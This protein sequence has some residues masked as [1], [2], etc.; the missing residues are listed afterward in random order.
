METFIIQK[1]LSSL[2]L[3]LILLTVKQHQLQTYMTR[4]P[5]PF[6]FTHFLFWIDIH[7]LIFMKSIGM[8]TFYKSLDWEPQCQS[9]HQ[10]LNKWINPQT[11]VCKQEL[12]Q[13]D[14]I[15]CQFVDHII[16]I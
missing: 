2:Y 4:Q 6:F 8:P 1:K 3:L 15:G 14:E 16:S 7:S 5:I 11:V 10:E 13:Y 12:K 9:L